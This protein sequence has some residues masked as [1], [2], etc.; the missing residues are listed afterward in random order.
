MTS[1]RTKM[2]LRRF[3]GKLADNGIGYLALD[4]RG[5][6][7]SVNLGLY[8]DFAKEGV[9]NDY[10]KMT[11][12]VDAAF[13]ERKERAGRKYCFGGRGYGGPMWRP[14]RP[15]CG[16]PSAGVAL[17]T[18]VTNFRDVLTIPPCASIKAMCLSPPRQ[19]DKKTFLE[20]SLLRNVAFFKL[21]R[22]QSG[23]CHGL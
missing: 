7:A 14:K 10:N 1:V 23:V 19:N 21:G 17:I 12:D 18:P 13:F 11:R 6:G 20:A 5:H 3:S 16:R 9:D 2:N 15:V 8:E 22:G 4:L